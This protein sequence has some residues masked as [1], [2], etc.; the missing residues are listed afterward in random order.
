MSG[1]RSAGRRAA[2]AGVEPARVTTEVLRMPHRGVRVVALGG[3]TGLPVLLRGLK[4]ALFPAGCGAVTARSR[5]RLTAI[6][7]VADDGG[8]S[9]R[10][11][12]A[13]RIL[14]PGDIRNCLLALSSGDPAIAAIF[15]FRFNGHGDV[16]GH[17]LGN[18]ILTAL[19]ELESSFPDAVERAGE[20]LAVRG[21]VLPATTDD[22]SL[23]AELADGSVVAGESRIGAGGRAIRRVRL[24]PDGARAL[25]RACEAI[26][27]ASL[28]VIGPGSLYTSLIPVLLVEELARAIAASPARVALVTSLMTEPGETDGYTPADFVTA[29]RRHAPAVPIHDVL[30]NTRPVPTE[31]LDRYAVEGARPIAA[32]VAPLRALGCRPVARDLLGAGPL[33]RHDPHRLARAVLG[34]ARRGPIDE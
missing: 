8:S 2:R 26:A 23:R 11:R 34:L 15:R 21:R 19:S 20:I 7:T 14:A 33:I 12:Q 1:A 5:D 18:L 29:I 3:G 24:E 6:V 28:V 25:P 17:S 31:L 13:Y 22:V 4:T 32:D 9:G 27:G 30:V 16:A 10:L